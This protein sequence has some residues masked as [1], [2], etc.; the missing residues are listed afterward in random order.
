MRENF[1]ELGLYLIIKAK[2]EIR[3]M[4]QLT[5]F[6]KARI[7][8]DY[9]EKTADRSL[10]LRKKF[11]DA[12]NK[13]LN[14]SL[15][16]NLVKAKRRVLEMKN[17]LLE[18]LN[19]GL[20]KCIKEKIEKNYNNYINFLIDTIK[21]QTHID[22]PPEI[23]FFLNPKDHKYF[24]KNIAKLKDYF[25][26]PVIINKSETNIIGGFRIKHQN[27]E[28]DYSIDNLIKR[29]SSIIQIEFT[30]L[31]SDALLKEID[32]NFEFFIQNQKVA[33]EEYLK[34]YDQI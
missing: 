4:N 29:S 15:S 25:T 10:R 26:N 23:N 18:D 16:S 19:D 21:S 20:R 27:I 22:K 2:S 28:Y 11:I 7:K 32:K 17:Q 6:Q 13:F 1:G 24:S 12:N 8:K 3:E 5:L 9:M 14:N 30:K 31:I 34:R 33:I